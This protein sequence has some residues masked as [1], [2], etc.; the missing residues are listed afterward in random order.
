MLFV[1]LWLYMLLTWKMMCTQ[2]LQSVLKFVMQCNMVAVKIF[3]RRNFY[4]ENKWKVCI[5]SWSDQ[6]VDRATR[7]QGSMVIGG[8]FMS[9]VLAFEVKSIWT[10]GM[11]DWQTRYIESITTLWSLC[12][13][14]LIIATNRPHAKHIN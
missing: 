3:Q 14:G 9:C 8:V 12:E 1:L 2:L 7:W 11:G 13:P 6:S 10:N 4:G 5:C